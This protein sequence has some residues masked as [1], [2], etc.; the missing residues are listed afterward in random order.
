MFNT[1]VSDVDPEMFGRGLQF[2]PNC[3]GVLTTVA[4]HCVPLSK[5]TGI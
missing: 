5:N 2:V 4:K 3:Q 1:Q